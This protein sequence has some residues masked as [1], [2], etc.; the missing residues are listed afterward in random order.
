MKLFLSKKKFRG[1]KEQKQVYIRSGTDKSAATNG[2]LSQKL[3]QR[4][5]EKMCSLNCFDRFFTSPIYF[6]FGG[7]SL[8]KE[9]ISSLKNKSFAFIARGG[10]SIRP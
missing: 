2:G 4:N 7:H 1:E 3:R 6:S 9:R 5:L 10:W 8:Q